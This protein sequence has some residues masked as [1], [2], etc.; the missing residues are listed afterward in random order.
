MKLLLT[1]LKHKQILV[2][3]YQFIFRRLSSNKPQSFI[4]LQSKAGTIIYVFHQQCARFIR[5]KMNR[6][7]LH[8]KATW[9]CLKVKWTMGLILQITSMET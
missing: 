2:P 4:L 1:F 8:S 6:V 3:G 7:V 9:P 5:I